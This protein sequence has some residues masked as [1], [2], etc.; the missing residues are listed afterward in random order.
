MLAN[1]FDSGMEGWWLYWE[2]S[3]QSG[4]EQELCSLVDS[5]GTTRKNARKLIS[6]S[7][8]RGF[9]E[10]GKLKGAGG[11]AGCPG[12]EEGESCLQTQRQIRLAKFLQVKSSREGKASHGKAP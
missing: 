11:P 12:A 2:A 3:S 8:Q 7:V 4:W 5:H 6:G 1:C 9:L 10:E